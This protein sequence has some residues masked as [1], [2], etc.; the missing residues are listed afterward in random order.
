MKAFGNIA[1]KA[2]FGYLRRSQSVKRL[3]KNP[4]IANNDNHSSSYSI[5]ITDFKVSK[6]M[7][8]IS[9]FIS[10][11]S[12]Y[13][14]KTKKRIFISEFIY[15]LL[16]VMMREINSSLLVIF[17]ILVTPSESSRYHYIVDIEDSEGGHESHEENNEGHQSLF[18][19][20]NRNSSKSCQSVRKSL[21][22]ILR[23]V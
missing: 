4:I 3:V 6:Q 20:T 18:L 9:Y 17:L 10:T 11:H 13:R 7:Y 22:N 19:V 5:K 15:Q 16:T 1:P 14:M 23:K 21:K 2:Y 8:R 12:S